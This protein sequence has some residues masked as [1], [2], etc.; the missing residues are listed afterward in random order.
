MYTCIL[1]IPRT[2][3]TQL[4][5]TLNTES[6]LQARTPLTVRPP[7]DCGT[8]RVR[9]PLLCRPRRL[10]ENVQFCVS[11]REQGVNQLAVRLDVLGVEGSGYRVW[12]LGVRIDRVGEVL[13]H[14]AAPLHVAEVQPPLAVP[15]RR[16]AHAH[17]EKV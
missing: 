16:P 17:N 11:W 6:K 13:L 12:G 7:H 10:T 15:R 4:P 3:N 1:F 8:L 14:G 9:K 5:K 2:R